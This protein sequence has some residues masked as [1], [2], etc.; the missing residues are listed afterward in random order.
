M[1]I[2]TPQS[3]ALN[4]RRLDRRLAKAAHVVTMLQRGE[5]L[6]LVHTRNGDQWIL[7]NGQPVAAGIAAMVIARA[8]VEPAGD[9]LLP[10]F[11]Q[12]YRYHQGEMK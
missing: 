5:S 1:T 8:D 7:S 3:R 2:H 6:Q 4:A 12:T 10:G 11:S 9:G